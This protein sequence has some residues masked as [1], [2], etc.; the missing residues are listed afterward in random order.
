MI[1]MMKGDMGI[2]LQMLR[3][4]SHSGSHQQQLEEFYSTQAGNYDAF[5]A[6]LLHGRRELIEHM[7]IQPGLYIAEL[8]AGTGQNLQYLEYPLQAYPEI[9]LVDLC[10]SLLKV[11]RQR[12]RELHN[13]HV[14]EADVTSFQPEQQLDRVYFSYALTMIPGW[15]AAIDRAI[16]MLKPG[17]LIGVVDFYI[18]GAAPDKMMVQH[19]YLARKFWKTWF[20]HDGVNLTP[21]HLRYLSTV[22]DT[23][24]LEQSR[25][26][27]PYLPFLKAPFYIF[28]GQKR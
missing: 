26:K 27:I 4:R 18:S 5:R 19:G 17:G 28:V 1:G 23:V 6:R 10:P 20:A 12:Y 15:K 11:A 21:E 22:T 3:G 25:G 24:S 2:L 8:G 13:I 16:N 9:Y 14:I 7:E